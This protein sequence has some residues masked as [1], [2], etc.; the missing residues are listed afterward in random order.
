M[1]KKL[2]AMFLAA[3]MAAGMLT[4]CGN[5]GDLENGGSRCRL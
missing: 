5:A 3:S 2:I 1:K 4:G